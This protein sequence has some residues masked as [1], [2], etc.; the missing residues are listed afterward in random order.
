MAM[1][2]NE[3]KTLP[4]TATLYPPPRWV[5]MLK[6]TA[7]STGHPPVR[8]EIRVFHK[9]NQVGGSLRQKR[10]PATLAPLAPRALARLTAA[11]EMGDTDDCLTHH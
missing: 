6:S 9:G 2:Q 5:R 1:R 7:F 11:G 10:K 8:S 3:T 4:F